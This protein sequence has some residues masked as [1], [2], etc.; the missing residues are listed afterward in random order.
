MTNVLRG[1]SPGYQ[2]TIRNV[3]AKASVSGNAEPG[4]I[5]QTTNRFLPL[6][7]EGQARAH[8]KRH[9]VPK[10]DLEET[11]CRIREENFVSEVSEV[12]CL[13]QVYFSSVGSDFVSATEV[14][15][16]ASLSP[17][18]TESY[19]GFLLSVYSYY[20]M[21]ILPVELREHI[22]GGGG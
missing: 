4:Y 15:H 11:L 18:E 12:L 21:L 14:S 5:L 16:T 9:G 13:G 17:P 1:I 22:R 10:G 19:Q 7:N 8:L 20:Q 6:P 2:G 3:E